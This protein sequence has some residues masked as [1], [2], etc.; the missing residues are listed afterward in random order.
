[1]AEIKP[2][3]IFVMGLLKGHAHN[4]DIMAVIRGL[5]ST[6]YVS[7]NRTRNSS[8]QQLEEMLF[9]ADLC[10]FFL[11]EF[12]SEDSAFASALKTA[13][14]V[15]VPVV[16]LKSEPILRSGNNS[17]D[18]LKSL[19]ASSVIFDRSDP[20]NTLIRLRKRITTVLLG[21]RI[22]RGILKLPRIAQGPTTLHVGIPPIARDRSV[23]SEPTKKPERLPN[24]KKRSA[25]L[26]SPFSPFS[27]CFRSTNY[28]VFHKN[29]VQKPQLVTFSH[30][31]WDRKDSEVESG[32]WG[33]ESSY[34]E[35]VE[36]AEIVLGSLD[37][38]T[39]S[40]TPNSESGVP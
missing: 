2:Y 33:S 36:R 22:D 6:F 14:A 4:R 17:S 27:D 9:V 12:T 20:E 1:M 30:S 28:L 3:N 21:R 40:V 24:V 15:N 11:N 29:K 5:S 37:I 25:S 16:A 23:K 18:K 7:R 32:I 10:L 26:G 34:E 31:F 13:D 38:P 19:D 8:L 39:P 35:D